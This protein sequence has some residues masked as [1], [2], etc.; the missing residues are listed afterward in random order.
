MLEFLKIM[1]ILLL[2]FM[3][4]VLFELEY[5]DKEGLVVAG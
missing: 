1:A 3:L 4:S 5:M 2:Y